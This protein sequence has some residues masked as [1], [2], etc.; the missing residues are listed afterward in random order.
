MAKVEQKQVVVN[1]ILGKLEKATSAVLIDGRGLTVD[2]DTKLRKALR[3]AN[4]DYK[5]Y[6]NTMIRFAISNTQFA[7]LD[8]HLSGPTTLAICYE[9]PTVAANI[10]NNFKKDA[11]AL[12]FKAGVIEGVYYDTEGMEI[13]A[14]IPS[15]EILLSRLL[16]SIQSPIGAFARVIKAVADNKETA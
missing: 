2:Q 4:V 1:E 8:S 9:D 7:E 3:E 6:K 10:I 11:S 16:G 14:D 5:V 15:K 13:I 12:E